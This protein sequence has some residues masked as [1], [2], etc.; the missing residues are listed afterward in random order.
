MTTFA[1]DWLVESHSPSMTM[2]VG[3]A[4][5]RYATPGLVVA[6][7][8][9]LGAGKTQFVRG[10]ARG[11]E[12]EEERLV[13]SPTFVLLQEYAGRLPIYHFDA[14]R[15]SAPEQFGSLG[16]EE[17][18][19]SDGVCLVEWADRVAGYLPQDRVVVHF[20]V[21]GP[22]IRRLTL[23][24]SGPRSAGVLTLVRQAAHEFTAAS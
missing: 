7:V 24:A 2:A 13:S 14:Y 12:V 11:L 5:G 10:V 20:D 23:A 8:G 19:D 3:A 18:F 9:P 1:H 16:P 17:Y 4:L 21:H 6:L 15:L 22:T